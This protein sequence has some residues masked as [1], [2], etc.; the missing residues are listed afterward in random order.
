MRSIFSWLIVGIL[1]F[2]PSPW[3]DAANKI[4]LHALFKDKAIL[5]IDGTRR[6]L[7]KGQ[8]SPEGV[9]LLDTDTQAEEAEIEFNGKR[10]VLKLGVVIAGFTQ[11]GKGSAT[12]W[13][14]PNGHYFVEGWVNGVAVRFMVDT[15]ATTIAMNSRVA[16]RIGLDYK[17]LGRRSFAST[18]SGI[19][20]TYNLKLNSVKVGGITLYNVDAGVIEGNFPVEVLLGMSFLGRLDIKRDDQKMELIQKY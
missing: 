15:G 9:K 11:P 2:L 19:V 16:K 14:E 13:A 1:L 5:M 4:A 18:A 8:T 3:T 20:R 12:L 7:A 10:E 17:K 6:V